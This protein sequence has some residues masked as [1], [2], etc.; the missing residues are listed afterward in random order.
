MTNITLNLSH[1]EG[2][3]PDTD[4]WGQ[5]NLKIIL[6]Y[7]LDTVND[8]TKL[9]AIAYREGEADTPVVSTKGLV[10]HIGIEL[11]KENQEYANLWKSVFK[12]VWNYIVKMWT[13]E[14]EFGYVT[15]EGGLWIDI[16]EAFKAWTAKQE[17]S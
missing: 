6:D 3:K 14:N 12:Q 9:A 10:Q 8:I 15:E 1:L 2:L 16:E 17:A 7:A 11:Y 4:E 13:D 5:A